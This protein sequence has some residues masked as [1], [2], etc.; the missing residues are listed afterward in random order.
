MDLGT[1]V[2]KLKGKA[3]TVAGR[4]RGRTKGF[5]CIFDEIFVRSRE[6]VGFWES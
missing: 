1:K 3:M 5:S 2:P 4:A 6:E